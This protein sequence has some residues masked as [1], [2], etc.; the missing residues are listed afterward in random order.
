M[1]APERTVFGHTEEGYSARYG[2]S[3]GSPVFEADLDSDART[4]GGIGDQGRSKGRLE[5]AILHAIG[6]DATDEERQGL[7]VLFAEIVIQTNRHFP[8]DEHR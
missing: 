3:L 8:S 5:A 4:H 7:A 6:P 2:E 1:S